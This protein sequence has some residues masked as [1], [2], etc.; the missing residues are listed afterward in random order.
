MFFMSIFTAFKDLW[1][2]DFM[3]TALASGL[4]IAIAS[5]PVGYFILLRRQTFAGDALSHVAFTSAVGS[6]VIGINP[7]AGMFAGATLAALSMAA[8]KNVSRARDT[9][10]G[11]VL[12]WI[13]GLGS[14]FLS[15]YTR[16]NS[17][18]NGAF[19]AAMLFGSI[20]GISTS[21]AML[22]MYISAA[23]LLVLAI[24]SRP[25]LFA[26]LDPAGAK[27]AGAPVNFL[28]VLFLIIAAAIAAEET[29][30]IGALLIFA[31][32]IAPAA[33]AA[34]LINRPYIA[35][36]A[37]SGI[38][39]AIT[40]IGLVLAVWLSLPATFLISALAAAVYTFTATSQAL[41]QRRKDKVTETDRRAA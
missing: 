28:N 21:Q 24:I 13:L 5:G 22:T 41:W 40:F 8:N 19:G 36:A 31:L 37:A 11:V 20:L 12:A 23:V 39:A 29:L 1:A 15:I 3:R 35:M 25:L 10:I 27:A 2:Y 38:A 30:T 9:H 34:K 7:F 16:S 18:G 4:A 17:G 14:L 32:L 26:S 33:S 6:V